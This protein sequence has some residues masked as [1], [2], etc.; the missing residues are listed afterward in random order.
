MIISCMHARHCGR[1]TIQS[2]ILRDLIGQN[3]A[4]ELGFIVS[5]NAHNDI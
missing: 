4:T 5:K 1:F 3:F 2:A